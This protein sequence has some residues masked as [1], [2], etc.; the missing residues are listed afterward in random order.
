MDGSEIRQGFKHE[1][2][3]LHCFLKIMI[4]KCITS[5]FVQNNCYYIIFL[6][7]MLKYLFKSAENSV[8]LS[9]AQFQTSNTIN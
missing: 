8:K 4:N 2:C 7:S 3:L 9:R 5:T 6:K 1:L